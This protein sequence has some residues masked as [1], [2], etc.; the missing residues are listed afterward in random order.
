MLR[1]ILAVVCGMLA[2]GI[3][4]GL[5]ES[6]SSSLYTAPADLDWND[7]EALAEFVRS[8][9]PA[10]M[11]LVIAAHAA[12][13]FVGA[14]VCVLVARRQ[15]LTGAVIV[16]SLFS[17]AGIANLISIPHPLW[18]AIVDVFVYLPSAWLGGIAVLRRPSDS[19]ARDV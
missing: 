18:F 17:L 6:L 12:G 13:A 14:A 4:V 1:K 5:I 9:P 8:I 15:W 3:V 2:G 11:G 10:A 19:A 7:A 16:G